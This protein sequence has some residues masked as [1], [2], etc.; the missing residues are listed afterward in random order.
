MAPLDYWLEYMGSPPQAQ[1]GEIIK[2]IEYKCY[3]CPVSG[4]CDHLLEIGH[5]LKNKPLVNC[6]YCTDKKIKLTLNITTDK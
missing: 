6:T 3:W 4:L 1:T 2:D 5:C